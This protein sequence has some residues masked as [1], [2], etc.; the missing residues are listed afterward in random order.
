MYHYTECGL[1]NVWLENGYNSRKTGYGDAVSVEDVDGL[2][3]LLALRLADKKGSLTA[4]ELRFLRTHLCLSQ[5]SLAKMLGVTDQS[6]SLWERK[7]RVPK[8]ADKLMRVL[9]LGNIDGDRRIGDVLDRINTVERIVNQRIVARET[10]KKW[11]AKIT[12]HDV[13]PA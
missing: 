2:H 5:A 4:T 7:G 8:S 6:I 3:A 10:R 13:L 11:T 1:R 12:D 9:V